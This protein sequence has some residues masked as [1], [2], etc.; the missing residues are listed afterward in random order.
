MISI[1]A[2]ILVGL[3]IGWYVTSQ[4]RERQAAAA[5]ARSERSEA[6]RNRPHENI[7]VVGQ[8]VGNVEDR[9]IPTG[10]IVE[11]K[12]G[13]GEGGD[14]DDGAED[15]DGAYRGGPAVGR[16]TGGAGGSVQLADRRPR[17]APMPA[18]PP[19]PFG[20]ESGGPKGPANPPRDV[21]PPRTVWGTAD[22]EDTTSS[23]GGRQE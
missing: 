5:R 11:A 8:P 12:G 20:R 4:N 13:A 6:R 18:E 2:L 14:A 7:C 3:C 9:Y 19:D 22:D 23:V 1:C 17:V 16:A 10:F 21:G 15:D